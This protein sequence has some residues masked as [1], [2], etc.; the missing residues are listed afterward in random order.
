[1]KSKYLF[2]GILI[3]LISCQNSNLDKFTGTYVGLLP[4]KIKVNKS[5]TLYELDFND[6]VMVIQNKSRKPIYDNFEL[7]D[8]Y[9][10]KIEILND[11]ISDNL[12]GKIEFDIENYLNVYAD[13]LDSSFYYVG[14]YIYNE[15]FINNISIQNNSLNF[16]ISLFSYGEKQKDIKAGIL[17][18][19]NE[20]LLNID[21]SFIGKLH[22]NNN[23][24]FDY[25]KSDRYFY[26]LVHSDKEIHDYKL[27]FYQKQRDKLR[28]KLKSVQLDNFEKKKVENSIKYLTNLIDL[29]E[30]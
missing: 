25:T 30:E 28:E 22:D 15:S 18:T 7:T 12:I 16:E 19:E 10:F 9:Y 20:K 13:T 17:F 29:Y 1:M 6:R 26:K 5:D 2:F 24:L 14:E 4:C 23:P 8:L 3:L 11:T 27:L 21:T